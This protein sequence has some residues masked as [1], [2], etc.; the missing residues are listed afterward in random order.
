MKEESKRLNGAQAQ[1][2]VFVFPQSDGITGMDLSSA[3]TW[4]LE[5]P[6]GWTGFSYDAE[7]PG[8]GITTY[9]VTLTSWDDLNWEGP[10]QSII[11]D[12][13]GDE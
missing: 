7:H 6:Y 2:Y 11:H 4:D 3:A 10:D 9:E 5:P 13:K 8:P 1:Q 12:L